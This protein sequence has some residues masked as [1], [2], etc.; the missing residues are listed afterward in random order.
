[1][2]TPPNAT[3]PGYNKG[4]R[5]ATKILLAGTSVALLFGRIVLALLFSAAAMLFIKQG[6]MAS[7][8]NIKWMVLALVSFVGS[9]CSCAFMVGEEI[10]DEEKA[11]ELKFR[12]RF[13]A[14]FIEI[15]WGGILALFL[16]SAYTS[17]AGGF[18]PDESLAKQQENAKKSR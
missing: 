18:I 14:K 2:E 9:L 5:D 17:N 10:L 1:M 7:A 16:I 13:R 4:H 3:P 8:K 12:L 11:Y 6:T 15:V